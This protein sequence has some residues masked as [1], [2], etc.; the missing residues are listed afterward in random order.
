MQCDVL[1][2]GARCA[3]A[4]LATFLARRGVSVIAV[5]KSALPSDY[6]L[7]TH[8]VHPSGMA[9]LDELGLGAAVRSHSPE[10]RT[11]RLDWHGGVLDVAFPEGQGEYCPRRERFDGLLQDAA[12]EAGAL[13]LER[14]TVR[15]LLR[16]GARVRGVEVE[17]RAGQR[18][19]IHARIVVGADGRKSRVAH[20]VGAEEQ[21][22]YDAPRGMYWG[23][24]PAPVGWGRTAQYPAGMYICREAAATRVAF[25][26]DGD[27][28]LLGALPLP[29]ELPRFRADPLGALRAVLRDDPL[30]REAAH[31]EP[32]EA[33]RGYVGE[34][35]FVRR[36]AGPGWLLVGDAGIYKDF[37]SGD[38]MS[39]ALIQARGAAHA[40]AIA[41]GSDEAGADRALE[42]FWRSRDVSSVPLFFHAQ[43][44]GA[45]DGAVALNRAVFRGIAARPDLRER[46][47]RTFARELSP[48]E[49]VGPGFALACVLREV[50]AG[51]PSA[52]G[53]FVRRGKRVQGVMRD[54]AERRRLL[55]ELT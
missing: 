47:A 2:V 29:H 15:A 28:L 49:V 27:R 51:T 42:R 14:T 21:L 45:L 38:G 52:L 48:F 31:A 41:L 5:D 40:I 32:D 19:T 25:H 10:M 22:G 46:F 1:I 17:D 18:L 54:L 12:R 35:Y 6:V 39:E 43:E 53:E 24:F 13:L 16:D 34:R 23:Y 50:V 44:L 11:C 7:S 3:G 9:V 26:T 20:W 4:A 36:A 8:T 33:V 30:L 37:L 55:A